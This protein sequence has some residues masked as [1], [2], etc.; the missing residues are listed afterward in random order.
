MNI[1]CVNV[2]DTDQDYQTK[3]ITHPTDVN[4]HTEP[5]PVDAIDTGKACR[6]PGKTGKRQA[7]QP[8]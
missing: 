5:V 1:N 6:Q 3:Q 7:P 2:Y 8:T 4:A